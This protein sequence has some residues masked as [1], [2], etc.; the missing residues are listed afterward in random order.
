MRTATPIRIIFKEA[1]ENTGLSY[2]NPHNFRNTLVQLGE[3][4]CKTPEEFKAWSQNLGHEKVMTTFMNYGQVTG[5][6]QGEIIREL[7]TPEKE[8]KT[9]T[10]EIF[11]EI[12]NL[13]HKVRFDS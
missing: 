7:V 13:L 4:I 10:N 6:R 2:F 1:F 12:S 11:R 5:Q 8:F 9:D 3:K